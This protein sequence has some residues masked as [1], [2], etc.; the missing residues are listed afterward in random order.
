MNRLV[1]QGAKKGCAGTIPKPF[2]NGMVRVQGPTMTT[3][4]ASRAESE[5][6]S[7]I[8]YEYTAIMVA[9]SYA[10]VEAEG[11]FGAYAPSGCI[12]M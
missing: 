2:H 10:N 12:G 6:N 8:T 7:G 1:S 5:T 11:T 4:A 9:A 3:P